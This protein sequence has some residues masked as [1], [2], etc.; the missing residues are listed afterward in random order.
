[1]ERVKLLHLPTLALIT[2]YWQD[3]EIN[4]DWDKPIRTPLHHS[5]PGRCSDWFVPICIIKMVKEPGFDFASSIAVCRSLFYCK[6]PMKEDLSA[7]L[8]GGGSTRYQLFIVLLTFLGCICNSFPSVFLITS[9]HFLRS[10]IAKP[11]EKL[12]FCMELLYWLS[13]ITRKYHKN[14]IF[15]V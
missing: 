1:M 15:T 6:V 12:I 13:Y 3:K 5:T 4:T 7:T 8:C 11:N 2:T 9:Q 10:N 14:I